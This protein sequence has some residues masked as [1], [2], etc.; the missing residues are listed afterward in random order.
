MTIHQS[1]GLE[2]PVVFV[3]SL[4]SVPRKG[5][6]GLNKI[7]LEHYPGRTEFEPSERIKVFDFWRL[8]YTAFSRPQNLLVLTGAECRE[9]RGLARL[10]SKYFLNS[11]DTIPDWKDAGLEAPE[12]GIV[13]VVPPRLKHE[14]AFTSHIAVYESCALQYKWFRELEFSPVR[15]NAALFG[16]LVHQ[17][18]EDAHKVVLVSCKLYFS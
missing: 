1:K 4:N 14:Y 9:G 12:F 13:D 3:G 8:Y 2:F 18:I 16:T 5:D 17:T 6:E 7:L 15:T 10:P 11:W